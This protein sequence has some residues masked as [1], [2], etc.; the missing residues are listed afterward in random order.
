MHPQI[1]QFKLVL[2]AASADAAVFSLHIFLDHRIAATASTWALLV[3]P[4]Y[5]P[6]Y[7]MAGGLAA[8]VTQATGPQLAGD[9]I[10]PTLMAAMAIVVAKRLIVERQ[11]I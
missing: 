9:L 11:E 3:K 2:I 1:R 7:G 8:R 10:F 4:P 6:P 5:G